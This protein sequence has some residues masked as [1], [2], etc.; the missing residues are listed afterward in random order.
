MNVGN[1]H[2]K[3]TFLLLGSILVIVLLLCGPLFSKNSKEFSV[4][5]HP[6]IQ[7]IKPKKPV[8]VKL[9]RTAGGK[10]TWD[11]T[12]DDVDEVVKADRR[13]RKLLNVK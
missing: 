12:G 11:L 13:L 6:K 4:G 1:T 10:Y 5:K 9:K 2:M 8:R 7:K 3:K